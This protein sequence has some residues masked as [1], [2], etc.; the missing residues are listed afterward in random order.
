MSRT[1]QG[2]WQLLS[3]REQNTAVANGRLGVAP[4]LIW[5]EEGGDNV[6]QVLFPLRG[7]TKSLPAMS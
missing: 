1:S 3:S 2:V 6:L 5:S 7:K 4:F